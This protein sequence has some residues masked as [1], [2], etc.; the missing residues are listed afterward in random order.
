MV[1]KFEQYIKED[2]E[3]EIIKMKTTL[4]ELF[5]RFLYY[6]RVTEY[7]KKELDLKKVIFIG[8]TLSMSNTLESLTKK[9][10]INDVYL[11]E[12]LYIIHFVTEENK[13]FVISNDTRIYWEKEVKRNLTEEDPY[14]EEDW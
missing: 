13:D 4:N 1:L 6:D 9:V 7:L 14:G 12:R 11:D 5:D 10:V 2:V 3:Y 8:K